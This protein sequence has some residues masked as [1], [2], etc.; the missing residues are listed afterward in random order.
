MAIDFL[1]GH[2]P[3]TP[4]EARMLGP[5]RLAYIGDSV[6]GLLVRTELL[7]TGA[8][9]HDVHVAAVARVNASAQAAAMARVEPL[10]TE[11]EADV[12]RARRNA[13]HAVPKRADPADYARATALEALLGYLYLTGQAERLQTL[14]DA[15]REEGAICRSAST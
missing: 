6:H 12:V 13:H 8:K 15:M 10:L 14:Y 2:A 1:R 3:L 9:A 7:L 4:R 11:D 5:I